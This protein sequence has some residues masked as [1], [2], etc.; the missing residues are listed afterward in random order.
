[1]RNFLKFFARETGKNIAIVAI[2][3]GIAVIAFAYSEPG[4]APTGG[5]VYAPIN[6]SGNA[7][8]KSGSLTIGP[9]GQLWANTIVGN[10]AI[11]VNSG[12]QYC[13]GVSCITAWSQA[14]GG[15]D[16]TGV[17]AGTGLSGGG[18]SG[19]VTLSADTSYLQRRVSGTCAAGS[20]IRVINADG[21][22][23]CEID[24]T[25]AGGGTP[26]G[27]NG[28]VQFNNS[29]SFGGDSNLF[30]DNTNKRLGI[31]MSSP[32]DK[33]EVN[34]RILIG[35]GAPLPASTQGTLSLSG[36]IYRNTA[37]S[38]YV[39]FMGSINDANV[40]FP[41]SSKVGT[42]Y[43]SNICVGDL[44][45]YASLGV[46]GTV[47]PFHY[48]VFVDQAGVP[49]SN[50]NELWFRGFQLRYAAN[51]GGYN[52]GL[53][54]SQESSGGPYIMRRNGYIYQQFNTDNSM[55]MANAKLNITSSGNVG[56]GTTNPGLPL[57]VVGAT[58]GQA[59]LRYTGSSSYWNIGADSGNALIVGNQNGVGVFLPNGGT[60]WN[61]MSDIRLKEKVLPITDALQ[62]V[63]QMRGV[64]YNLKD[65]DRREVG[66]IAQ[67]VQP[68]F[69]E[70]VS[71]NSD[72]YLGVSYDR[73]APV[74]IEAIKEQQKEIEALKTEIE[75]LKNR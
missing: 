3:G 57:E 48:M 66:V 20:S 29:G 17:L 31:G 72:G 4:A 32:R 46:G 44:S 9:P 64:V 26:G 61:A 45:G 6:T 10:T 68:Y 43:C 15:G 69:P 27:S 50:M 74:L 75:A 14:G 52:L 39:S 8:A 38:S 35:S 49:S 54:F 71:I 56:I 13:I 73:I 41:S 21:T 62:K 12:G 53:K 37:I 25:G 59:R 67:E 7:Q 55:N 16:I 30:W 24:D 5:T 60:G 51:V 33:L 2:I 47:N 65:N 22:V 23:S 34:G 1:M 58:W 36:N 40:D 19:S 18:S 42:G 11:T 28:Q 70:L 63:L